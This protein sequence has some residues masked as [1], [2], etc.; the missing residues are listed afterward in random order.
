VQDTSLTNIHGTDCI[1]LEFVSCQPPGTEYWDYDT[2][3]L[4]QG[5]QLSKNDWT[6]AAINHPAVTVYITC[7]F[8][9]MYPN[10]DYSYS[11]ENKED[12]V[13]MALTPPSNHRESASA[14]ACG[15][16]EVPREG[17]VTQTI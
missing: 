10:C 15:A 4:M 1:K 16:G 13:N 9:Y 12:D 5:D 14:V 6:K 8:L 7:I 17:E 3:R 2:G 11:T